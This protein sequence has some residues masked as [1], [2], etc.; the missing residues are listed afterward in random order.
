MK[1]TIIICLAIFFFSCDQQQEGS[2]KKRL[3]K[4]TKL[5]EV[6]DKAFKAD[7][8][9]EALK[10]Y[11]KALDMKIRKC[12]PYF[13][14]G[15]CKSKLGDYRGAIQDYNKAIEYVDTKNNLSVF[16]LNR[17]ICKSKLGDYRGAIQDCIRILD[18]G[19][20]GQKVFV[21]LSL[22]YIYL[23]NLDY[24][25]EYLV[26]AIQMDPK[27][28]EA[29]RLRGIVYL[30]LGQKEFGCLDLSKAGELGSKEAYDII[31]EHCN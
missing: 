25:L 13:Y 29:Y 17:S 14:R 11:D 2:F 28:K 22:N 1:Y 21:Q 26:K 12:Y 15:I 23:R 4:F 16:Y 9:G 24:A 18:N 7:N 5:V 20:Y 30:E 6:A 3:N 19:D 31:R 8:Y 27:D 10:R